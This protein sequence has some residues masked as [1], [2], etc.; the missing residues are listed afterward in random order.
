MFTL[1]AVTLTGSPVQA[2]L[3]GAAHAL[4]ATL[5]SLPAGALVDR[6]NRK[7]ILVACAATGAVMYTSVVAA[8]ALGRLTIW[9]L[10]V[11][12]L[13]T[14]VSRAF[15]LPAQNAALR[16]IVQPE[17][18]ATAMSANEGREHFAG[19]VGAP[20]G[21]VLYSVG[22]VIPV[23]FDAISYA[24]LAV[25]FIAIR[26][27]LL[28]PDHPSAREPILR[29]IRT[30]IDWVMAQRAIRV[31][32]MSAT[33]LNFCAQAIILVLIVNLQQRGTPPE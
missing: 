8:L 18:M 1:L 22:R 12:A 13:T 17:D 24:V 30:G 29:S 31:I 27:P 16:A 33:V 25:A 26:A 7:R 15:F 9:H 2:G 28:A 10:A 21:G 6:W 11:V 32:A 3:V 4:G 14:G 20:V 23:I 5:A 19:L